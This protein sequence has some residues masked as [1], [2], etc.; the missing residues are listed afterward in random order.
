M[1]A[2]KYL[3][4]MDKLLLETPLF[5]YLDISAHGSPTDPST[6]E[7][8]IEREKR[9][10]A[11]IPWAIKSEQSSSVSSNVAELPLSDSATENL[12]SIQVPIKAYRP[13]RSRE[14]TFIT[15]QAWE[16]I[17]LEVEAEVFQARLTS[18]TDDTPDQY[19]EIYLA[20]VD[21]AD[22]ALV[23]RGA[24]F[25]W[26]IGY[27]QKP[28]GTTMRASILRFRRMPPATNKDIERAETEIA[29]WE[30]LFAASE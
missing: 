15:L 18:A 7:Q 1:M 25:Y 2:D 10:S 11:G 20:E 4:D 14:E 30:R 27:L 3:P 21:R 12:A 23:R 26:S 29:A 6:P 22:Q 16:G 5:T 13:E 19:A 8:S 28:T 9:L 17:V 24:V